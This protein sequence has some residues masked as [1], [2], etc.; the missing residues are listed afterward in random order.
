MAANN[1]T[2]PRV[3]N[4]SPIKKLFD[5]QLELLLNF[6]G[7]VQLESNAIF[8]LRTLGVDQLNSVLTPL[9]TRK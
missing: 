2:S 1:A 6:N 3:R 9:K 8:F 4:A 5:V 7:D